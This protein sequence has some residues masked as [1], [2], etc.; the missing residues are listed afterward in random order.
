MWSKRIGDVFLAPESSLVNFYATDARIS[1]LLLDVF[2]V[3][4]STVG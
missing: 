2:D 3:R 1:T 4:K